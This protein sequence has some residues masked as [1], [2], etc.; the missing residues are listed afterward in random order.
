MGRCRAG[1]LRAANTTVAA[2]RERRC[3]A[4]GRASRPSSNAT[5]P[6]AC[7]APFAG[8][9][10]SRQERRLRWPPTVLSLASRRLAAASAPCA[11]AAPGCSSVVKAT[12]GLVNGRPS[13]LRRRAIP[14]RGQRPRMPPSTR[15]SP[16][17]WSPATTVSYCRSQSLGS[18]VRSGGPTRQLA[19]GFQL[20][21]AAR[22]GAT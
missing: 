14:M 15:P 9:Q 18:C 19:L 1:S 13:A 17:R 16:T 10:A 5:R 11:L 8:P 12:V 3:M 22:S 21:G 20:A 2:E 7:S 6:R 4:A